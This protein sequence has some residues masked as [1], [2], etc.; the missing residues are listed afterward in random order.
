MVLFLPL[1]VDEVGFVLSDDS[2]VTLDAMKFSFEKIPSLM[3]HRPLV[4]NPFTAFSMVA[5]LL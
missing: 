4:P 5:V 2:S 1:F 3:G